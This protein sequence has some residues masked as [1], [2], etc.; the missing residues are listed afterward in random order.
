MCSSIIKT[1]LKGAFD[2][3][4][5]SLCIIIFI[6]LLQTSSISAA[7]FWSRGGQHRT[8]QFQVTLSENSLIPPSLLRPPLLK[9]I[10]FS[11]SQRHLP[12]PPASR[13]P[14][15]GGTASAEPPRPPHGAVPS[16]S[17]PRCTLRP[18]FHIS[19]LMR[20]IQPS[21]R[22]KALLVSKRIYTTHQ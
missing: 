7:S 8:Q 13:H 18:F 21:Q 1:P 16:R 10:L 11:Y 4:P 22:Q 20:P 12:A 2:L 14:R 3:P 15:A 6:V 5:P 19:G 17:P 9:E